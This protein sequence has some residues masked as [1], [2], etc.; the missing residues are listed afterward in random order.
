MI[1][2]IR[3]NGMSFI[4]FHNANGFEKQRFFDGL[5]MDHAAA[6]KYS[7]L[8]GTVLANELRRLPGNSVARGGT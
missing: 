2:T 8:L 6:E 4:D 1:T 5:H 3:R 7:R